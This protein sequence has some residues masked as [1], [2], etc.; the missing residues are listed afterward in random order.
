MLASGCFNMFN[1]KEDWLLVYKLNPKSN[2]EVYAVGFGATTKGH[3]EIKKTL[4]SGSDVIKIIDDDYY[5]Y[6]TNIFKIND[7][8][9]KITFIDTSVFRGMSKSFEFNIHDRLKQ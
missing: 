4:G 6:K 2:L 5:G 1:R 9:L 8:L 7:T 3:T